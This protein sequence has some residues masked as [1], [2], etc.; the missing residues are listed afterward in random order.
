M[1]SVHYNTSISFHLNPVS[2]EQES[3]K[4]LAKPALKKPTPLFADKNYQSLNPSVTHHHLQQPPLTVTKQ[5][6]P[7]KL[8]QNRNLSSIQHR[9]HLRGE[10]LNTSYPGTAEATAESHNASFPSNKAGLGA[11]I[12]HWR[13]AKL[14]HYL[15]EA[16]APKQTTSW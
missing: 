6:H 1:D 12:Q 4:D 5:E 7:N 9:S 14:P 10:E 16:V 13:V 3:P 8:L 11:Q 15:P 2:V